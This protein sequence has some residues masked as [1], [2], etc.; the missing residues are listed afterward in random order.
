ML[1]AQS[2]APTAPPPERER[3]ATRWVVFGATVDS[4]GTGLSTVTVLLYFVTVIGFDAV[5]VAAAMSVGAV[6]GLLSPVPTG[7]L[8]D[9]V[10]LTRIYCGA[11]MLRGLGFLAYTVT[12]TFGWFCAVTLVLMT[13]ETTTTSL[14]QT[15]VGAIFSEETRVRAMSRISAGR[16]AALGAGTLLAGLALSTGSK[17]LLVSLLAANGLSFFVFSLIVLR[18]RRQMPEAPGEAAAADDDGAGAAPSVPVL[19]N[20][21]FLALS[22]SNGLLFLHDAV[23]FEL[24]PLWTVT[25]LHVSAGVMS[26][27][28]VLNT[29]LSIGLQVLFGRMEAIT[30]NPR[31]VLAV[32][33]ALLAAACAAG[34]WTEQGL[35]RFAVV[36]GCVLVVVLLTVGENLHSLAGWQVSFDLSP[37]DRRGEYTAAFNMSYG[38]QRAIG[39][40]LT[41]G[42]V[43]G[44]GIPGWLALSAVFGAGCAGFLAFSRRATRAPHL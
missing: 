11:L 26:A 16:N 23:L 40:V 8:A 43:L 4:L 30:R 44:H 20:V 38:L 37:E 27:L 17:P 33:V 29:V 2:T 19:R 21:R 34:A 25:Q 18:L 13:L 32:A 41:V 35:P 7:W 1:L 36:G 14:Q 31:P 22:A 5:S 42:L 28:L 12:G 24:L 3:S 9:R 15:L 6:L 10:G 39:P